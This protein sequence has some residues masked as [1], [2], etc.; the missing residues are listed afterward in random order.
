[1]GVREA[2]SLVRAPNPYVLI[3]FFTVLWCC[4]SSFG[5]RADNAE[6]DVLLSFKDSLS[7]AGRA[8]SSWNSSVS[9]CRGNRGNWIGVL[10]FNGKVRGLRLE[11][12]G[13]KGVVD[14]NYL[15]SMPHLRTLSVMN[16]TF[17]G[18]MPDLKKLS[19][20]RSVYLSY[21]HFSGEIPGDAFLGMRYLKKISLTHNEFTGKIPSS[22]AALPR[23]ME[24]RLDGNKFQGPI[25]DLQQPSLKR[26][27]VSNNELDGPIPATLTK[28]DATSFSGTQ[29]TTHLHCMML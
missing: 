6:S 25:P 4:M 5:A 12:M 23:L 13:L 24:L 20:L 9:P 15:A 7:N 21:N 3:F 1:M 19:K 10:C 11:N 29:I 18:S 22:L 14:V 8:L 2:S 27:N 28:M 16:N 26:L 17:A